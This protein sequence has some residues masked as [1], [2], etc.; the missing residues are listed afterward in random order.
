MIAKNFLTQGNDDNISP[1]TFVTIDMNL[2]TKND[3][4][5][6]ENKVQESNPEENHPSASKVDLGVRGH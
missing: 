2:L 3:T 4:K 1:G 6:T 5:T